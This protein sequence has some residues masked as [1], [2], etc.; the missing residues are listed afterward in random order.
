M[1]IG[2]HLVIGSGALGATGLCGT[3]VYL[4][5]FREDTLET[6]VKNYF[7]D[8][9]HMVVLDSSLREEWAKF[10]ELYSY[11]KGEKP[12]G[13][14]KDQIAK[15]CEDKLASRDG[16]SF[17]LVKKWCVINK[18]S[19]KEEA[20]TSDRKFI[21]TSESDANEQWKRAWTSY[22][23][24]KGD[25]DIKD[26]VFNSASK[27]AAETGGPALKKWCEDKSTQFMYEYLGEDRGYEKYYAWCTVD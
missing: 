20:L 5:S 22:N 3:S 1:A 7:R 27:N 17:E 2:K 23:T 15:W 16:D 9:K 14:D 8:K 6:R 18:R 11:S 4:Y 26:S 12:K 25:L 10:K 13:I 24:T 19:L 21:P